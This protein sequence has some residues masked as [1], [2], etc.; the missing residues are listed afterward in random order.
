ME[1]STNGKRLVRRSITV[2][3][4]IAEVYRFWRELENL[5]R[6]SQNLLSVS[7]DGLKSHWVAKSPGG[8]VEWD[9]EITDDVQNELLAWRSLPGSEIQNQ[10]TV[11]FQAA[12]GDRGTEVRVELIYDVPAGRAGATLARLFGEEPDQQLRDDLRRFK[13]VLETGE[14]VL[15]D[16]SLEGA[17][18]GADKQRPAQPVHRAV[19]S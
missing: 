5:P 1:S 11:K 15:S 16:G 19:R 14:V 17:G 10:G 2:N 13:Q 6:Y 9:S 3:R 7:V 4:P 8:T 12:P 18:Q